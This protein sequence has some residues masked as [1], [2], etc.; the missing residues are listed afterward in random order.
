MRVRVVDTKSDEVNVLDNVV[1]NQYDSNDEFNRHIREIEEEERN[2]SE[3]PFVIDMKER[4]KAMEVEQEQMAMCV[5]VMENENERL[6]AMLAQHESDEDAPLNGDTLDKMQDDSI[7]VKA[8]AEKLQK[9]DNVI[10]DLNCCN[11]DHL[12]LIAEL[13]DDNESLRQLK[14][15][16]TSEPNS[17]VQEKLQQSEELSKQLTQTNKEHKQCITILESEVDALQQTI[18]TKDA[19]LKAY[20]EKGTYATSGTSTIQDNEELYSKIAELHL[21]K[22]DYN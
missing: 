3:Y 6:M 16:S 18:M 21:L 19:G 10:R 17:Q 22:A 4:L 8:I 5:Q 20:S 12:K 2:F 15:V 11:K 1:V 14:S 9:A 7:A 13:E